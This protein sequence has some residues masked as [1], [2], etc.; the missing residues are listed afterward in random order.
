M[1]RNL[2]KIGYDF[3][4][5]DG[6][7]LSDHFIV[8]T[9]NMPLCPTLDP[10]YIEVD[11]RPGVWFTGNKIGTRDITVGLGILMDNGQTREDAVKA[12]VDLSDKLV[13]NEIKKLEIGNG[14]YVNAAM[15]GD[16]AITTRGD[17]G[18]VDVSFRCFDP[19]VYGADHAVQ[20][21]SGDNNFYVEGKLPTF[22]T[23]EISGA[24]TT[25]ITNKT[26][27]DKIKVTKIP[28]GKTVVIDM[29]HHN[30][31]AG[32]VYVAADPTISDFWTINPG[33]VTINVSSGSG[34][35]K[36]KEVYL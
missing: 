20:L 34:T 12:W 14:L 11:G 1:L 3:L 32:D 5:Y 28:T 17:W 22:P 26:T 19:Y 29:E 2:G 8:R 23:I 35:L 9:F 7:V 18:I 16:S 10:N 13:K 31:K 24:T 15:V 33:N 27:S 36:Y 4:V 6:V 30:C 21:K 25:T